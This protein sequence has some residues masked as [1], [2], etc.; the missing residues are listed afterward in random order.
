VTCPLLCSL[1]INVGNGHL[2]PKKNEK[3]SVWF[4][5]FLF[6]YLT[7][8]IQAK[9]IIYIYKVFVLLKKSQ[10]IF[11]IKS[12]QLWL[13]I[14]L[15]YIFLLKLSVCILRLLS[16]TSSLGQIFKKIFYD[17]VWSIRWINHYLVRNQEFFKNNI[18]LI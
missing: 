5:N 3:L 12:N 15:Q 1:V 18:V 6:E 8:T 13:L 16:V 2:L 9:V 11:R 17:L 10:I 14:Y 4:S 7:Y